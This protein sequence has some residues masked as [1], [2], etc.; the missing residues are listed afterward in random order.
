MIET[1]LGYIS[2]LIAIIGIVTSIES[3]FKWKIFTILPS[4]V[5]IYAAI[6]ILSSLG[7]WSQSK[8]IDGAYKGLKDA[9]LPAM[10]F[11]ML[12]TANLKTISMLG[13]KMIFTFIL[14]TLSIMIGFIVSF[15]LIGDYL[16]GADAYKTIAALC[17]SWIGGTGNMMAIQSALGVSSE[18]MGYAL[19]TD[20][21]NYTIWV[22]LLL[23]LVSH[24]SSFN[25]WSKADTSRIDEISK[26][27]YSDTDTVSPS[28][29]SIFILLGIAFMV[30]VISMHI[31]KLLPS[32]EFLS[33]S[34]WH[35]LMVTIGG[36]VAAMTPLGKKE[37]SSLLSS[38]MLYLIV[39]LIASRAD[40]SQMSQ[41]P[42][43]ILLGAIVLLVHAILMTVFAKIF[44][45]DLFSIGVASLANI[46]GVASAPILASA[47]SKSLVPIGVLMA[48]LGYIIGTAGGL[49]VGKILKIMSS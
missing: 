48:M 12:L 27:L 13:G 11:L 33:T 21:I 14:A 10:I 47:Y 25:R 20:S 42:M 30:N 15:A 1:P 9:L 5:I 46:G 49:I 39:A 6:M 3:K 8:E 44:K 35:I 43:Y 31:A 16:N 7:I 34:T 28:V 23:S 2:I 19:I 18:G 29:S 17:G 45:L 26:K 22:M 41:A 40:F 24:A 38:I 36:I 37:G 4:I 32:S